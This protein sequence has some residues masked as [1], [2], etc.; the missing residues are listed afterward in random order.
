AQIY[1][2]S[3][4]PVNIPFKI[5]SAAPDSTVWLKTRVY[6]RNMKSAD[7]LAYTYFKGTT[8][9]DQNVKSG[10]RDSIQTAAPAYGQSATYKGCVQIW[11]GGDSTKVF[12]NEPSC[13]TW[14]YTRPQL[15]PA[16]IDSVVRLAIRTKPKAQLGPFA[17]AKLADGSLE[18]VRD[19]HQMQVCAFFQMKDS[20]WK[21][22]S[23]YD[24]IPTCDTLYQQFL[25]ER[26]G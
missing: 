20:T 14:I 5:I 2:A 10:T 13:W 15:P 25:S 26:T 12:P 24:N 21:K 7:R 3:T 11:Y 18:P 6:V 19:V 8:R 1:L 9:L 16:T 22:A 17:R 23:N 4:K